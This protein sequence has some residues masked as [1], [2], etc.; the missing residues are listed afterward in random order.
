MEESVKQGDKN[1]R[2]RAKKIWLLATEAFGE[3]LEV[4][5]KAI[6]SVTKRW[7]ARSYMVDLSREDGFVIKDL[8][9]LSID[10]TSCDE[11]LTSC[12]REFASACREVTSLIQTELM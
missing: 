12:G 6:P 9:E 2:V 4:L 10:D 3:M 7:W 8:I 1:N 11:R 5:K